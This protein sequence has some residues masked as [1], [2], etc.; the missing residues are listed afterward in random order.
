MTGGTEEVL[1]SHPVVLAVALL[2]LLVMVVLD[3]AYIRRSKRQAEELDLPKGQWLR[4][5]KGLVFDP[6]FEL[7]VIGVLLFDDLTQNWEHAAVGAAGAVIGVAVGRYRFRIQYV[8]AVP[9]LASIVFVR[10]R[11]DTAVLAVLVL[12]RLAAEQNEVPVV[13]PLTLLVT[14]GLALVLAESAG[15]SWFSYRRYVRDVRDVA[16]VAA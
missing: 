13:G 15:R 2:V 8:R 3:I 11:A 10:S 16:G 4:V 5:V 14:F 7:F 9:E 12:V 1:D 6:M